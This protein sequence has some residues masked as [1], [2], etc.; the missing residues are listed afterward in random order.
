MESGDKLKRYNE[1]FPDIES[2]AEAFDKIAS[3]FYAGNFG[4]MAKSDI[5]VL[6]FHLYIEQVLKIDEY[7][8]N[9]YSDFRMSKELG[10]SQN[11]ISTLKVKKQLQYPR[12]FDW[13]E[14]FRRASQKVRYDKGQIIFQVPDINLYYEIKNAIEEHN[15]YVDVS[16]TP[17]LLKVPLEYFLD[18]MISVSDEYTRKELKK[19]IRRE[20]RKY[21]GEK[22]FI[23]EETIHK[24][25]LG[26]GKDTVLCIIQ[27]IISNEKLP[28]YLIDIV[29]NVVSVL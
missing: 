8:F 12:N 20:Y 7:N 23:E 28:G 19:D 29:K 14:S 17:K 11:K 2:K 3:C 6:M 1:L 27:G 22:E 24:Q 10:V 18:L 16:L 9:T 5:E 15:G 4:M 26:I 13:K 25:L 21:N